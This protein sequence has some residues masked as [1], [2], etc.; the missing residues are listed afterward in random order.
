M[1]AD[2]RAKALH[3]SSFSSQELLSTALEE[4]E[5]VPPWRAGQRL[6]ASI[7]P[8]RWRALRDAL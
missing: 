6:R 7:L 1:T 4:D 2:L 3:W 5:H 8:A